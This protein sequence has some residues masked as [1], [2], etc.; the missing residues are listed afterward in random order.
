MKY[1]YIFFLQNNSLKVPCKRIRYFVTSII[2]TNVK[3]VLNDSFGS[4]LELVPNGNN[5]SSKYHTE[6]AA[7]NGWHSILFIIFYLYHS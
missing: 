1:I 4:G 2:L 7:I 5:T 6:Q 3:N